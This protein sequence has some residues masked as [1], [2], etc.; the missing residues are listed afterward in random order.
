VTESAFRNLDAAYQNFFRRVKK[1]ADKK[2][3][4]KFRSRRG[5]KSFTIRGVVIERE[6][7]R[8]PVLGWFRLAEKGYL[9][10]G[11]YRTQ[12]VT[13]S[14]RADEWYVSI[15]CEI[16]LPEHEHDGV[17]GIDLGI[18]SLAVCSDGATFNN[19]KALKKYERKKAQLQREL[20]RRKQGSKN[21]GKTKDKIRKLEAKIANIRRHTHHNISRHVTINTLPETIVL[22]DL[23][24]AGMIKN[25][26]LAKAISDAGMG[27][28]GRQIEYKAEWNGIAIIKADRWFPSSK[29]CSHCG[30]IKDELT[31]AD[32]TFVCEDCGFEID[33]DLNAAINLAALGRTCEQRGVACGVEA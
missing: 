7:I 12:A 18:K 27:E 22:E 17:L 33:R 30:C 20:S 2:G 13:I 32:R 28:L 26:R 9:P 25:R 1:G 5:K 29:T 14:E 11:T 31:L 6:K 21:W 23:N 19:P 8:L 24:V 4:P 16:E 10:E 3:F 15:Q